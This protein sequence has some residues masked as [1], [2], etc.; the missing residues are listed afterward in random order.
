[1]TVVLIS[2]FS[3]V[4][5][6]VYDQIRTVIRP[7]LIANFVFQVHHWERIVY[8][9]IVSYIISAKNGIMRE[10]PISAAI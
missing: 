4:W 8:S 6:W 5:K 9:K 10:K 1:M 3:V 7:P 2:G